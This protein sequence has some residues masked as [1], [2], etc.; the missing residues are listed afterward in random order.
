MYS[1]EWMGYRVSISAVTISGNSG[2]S[3][4]RRKRNEM[5]WHPV[6]NPKCQCKADVTEISTVRTRRRGKPPK[7]KKAQMI[8]HY[9]EKDEAHF[10]HWSDTEVANG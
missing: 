10:W 6:R 2:P 7:M 4:L 8:R 9:R 3:F 1:P 5:K